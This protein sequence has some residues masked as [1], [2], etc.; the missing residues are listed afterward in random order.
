MIEELKDNLYID[1]WLTGAD[2][3]EEGCKLIQEASDVMNQ[4]AMP[5]AKWVSN[6]PA[7]AEVLHRDFKDK[8]IDAESV[9]VLG[10]KWLAASDAFSFSIA[11]LPD[12]LCITK[13]IV[14]SYLSRLFDPLGIAAPYVMGIKCLFQDLWRAGLQWD[15][16]L[17][18]EFRV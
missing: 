18:S 13:R 12:G 17:P 8:F 11:S 4:A 9:K 16:E 10:M 15:D 3:A 7:V 1:D 14:L 5:L 6:S 2:S